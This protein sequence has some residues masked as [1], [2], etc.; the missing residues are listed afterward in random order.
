MPAAFSLPPLPFDADALAPTISADT[1][2]QH[3]G[4]HHKAYV[5]KLNALAEAEGLADATLVEIIRETAD[6]GPDEVSAQVSAGELFVHAAQHFNHS[7]FWHSLSPDGGEPD[8]ALLEAIERD[9]GSVDKLAEE[10]VEAGA[11]HFASGWVWLVADDGALRV[12][13]THDAQTPVIDPGLKPLLVIDLWEH[14]YYLD[15]QKDRKAYLEAVT[16]QHLNWAFAAE[17]LGVDE[18]DALDI[19]IDNDVTQTA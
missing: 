4:G 17:A 18:A 19:G 1:F 8:G 13:S 14:A 15:H 12:M 16:K 2:A 7:F 10:M 5:E 3:H 11:D 6:A 9:F